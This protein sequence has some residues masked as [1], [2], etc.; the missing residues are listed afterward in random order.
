MARGNPGILW[1]QRLHRQYYR[2]LRECAVAIVRK[3][4]DASGGNR[5]HAASALGL[6]RTH[7]LKIMIE[8]GLNR[9]PPPPQH[10]TRGGPLA[11]RSRFRPRIGR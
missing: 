4:L 3:A 11:W 8:L 2:Q 10:R 9:I 1:S 5:T 7:L 6:E